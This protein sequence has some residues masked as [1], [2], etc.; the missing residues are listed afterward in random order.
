MGKVENVRTLL[1]LATYSVF[2]TGNVLLGCAWMTLQDHPKE[3]FALAAAGFVL[4][5][6]LFG[7]IA[8]AAVATKSEK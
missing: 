8:L 1:T 3:K 4:I 6:D 7:G 5:L 2:L